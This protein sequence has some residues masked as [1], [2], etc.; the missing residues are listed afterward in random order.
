MKSIAI[1]RPISGEVWPCRQILNT[2]L[3]TTQLYAT[4]LL[5]RRLRNF[6]KE[7]LVK[8]RCYAIS[9]FTSTTTSCIHDNDLVS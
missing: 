3:S 7:Y 1:R 8:W 4:F 2:V 5:G 9:Q 6:G